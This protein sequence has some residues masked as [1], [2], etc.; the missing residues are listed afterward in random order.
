[1]TDHNAMLSA[2][3]DARIILAALQAVES[4]TTPASIKEAAAVYH[5]INATHAPRVARAYLKAV[6]HT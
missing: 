1:M 2:K 4:A 6:G 3:Y 5:R